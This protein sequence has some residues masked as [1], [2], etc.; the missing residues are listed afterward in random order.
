M[1]FL[2]P[3]ARCDEERAVSV[4]EPERSDSLAAMEAGRLG[5]VPELHHAARRDRFSQRG[6]QPRVEPGSRPRAHGEALGLDEGLEL[7]LDPGERFRAQGR[8]YL[9]LE[10]AER[11]RPLLESGPLE[12]RGGGF[13]LR[14][15]LGRDR[16]EPANRV[17]PQAPTALGVVRVHEVEGPE[18]RRDRVAHALGGPP[19]DSEVVLNVVQRESA[20]RPLEAHR[21]SH[22]L[23]YL[24]VPHRADFLF[25]CFDMPA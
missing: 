14:E 25:I 15:L 19:A 1:R 13:E 10:L 4:E 21:E 6:E 3:V 22:E 12:G 17:R 16:D 7:G 18:R 5:E 2:A 11:G 24:L 23:R 8:T 9:R 20:E